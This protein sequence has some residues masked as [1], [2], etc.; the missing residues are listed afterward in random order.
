MYWEFPG[1]LVVRIPHF[2]CRGPQF[3]VRELRSHKPR[4]TAKKKKKKRIR[5]TYQS[6]IYDTAH[7]LKILSA[8]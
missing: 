2:H 8:A 3:L 4:G 7:R 5:Y 1:G 6:M